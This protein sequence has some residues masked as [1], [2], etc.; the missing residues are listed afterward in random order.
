MFINVSFFITKRKMIFMIFFIPYI[1]LSGS[2]ANVKGDLG[3]VNIGGLS[4]EA[5]M[6][7][8]FKLKDL[9]NNR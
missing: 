1:Q 5:G 7:F 2:Y 3:K 6:K 4:L 9:K 8:G